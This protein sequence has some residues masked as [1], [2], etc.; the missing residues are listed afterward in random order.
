[1]IRVLITYAEGFRPG[2][3][4]VRFCYLVPRVV[5]MFML[6][7]TMD[8]WYLHVLLTI[9]SLINQYSRGYLNFSATEKSSN[10]FRFCWN[11]E[12]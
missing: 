10:F 4:I 8:I 12:S 9:Q 3:D 6:L 11:L 2:W 7:A 1:M 5:H